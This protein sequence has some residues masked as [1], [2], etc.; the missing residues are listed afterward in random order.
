MNRN[1]QIVKNI[2]DYII[3]LIK[4]KKSAIIVR[5]VITG[6]LPHSTFPVRSDTDGG[7][8]LFYEAQSS[9]GMG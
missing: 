8:E 6:N 4:I 2:L 3:I 1:R 7:L 9:Y 5:E